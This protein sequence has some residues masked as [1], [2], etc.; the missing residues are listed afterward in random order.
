MIKNLPANAGD[1]RDTVHSLGWEDP[2][3]E[4][5]A[6][7]SGGL[8]LTAPR[9]EEPGRLQSIRS[10]SRTRLQ[11]PSTQDKMKRTE[12]M[13][14]SKY[15]L[16]VGKADLESPPGSAVVIPNVSLTMR[17]WKKSSEVRLDQE[18]QRAC[19]E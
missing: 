8:T 15:P 14:M 4:E 2:L 12:Q 18:S 19:P 6:T 10:Q 9:T 1:V 11:R 7:H 16:C 3:E 5:M 17:P 13:R